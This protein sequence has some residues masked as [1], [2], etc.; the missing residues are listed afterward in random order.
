MSE[1]RR[2]VLAMLT[3]SLERDVLADALIALILRE[4]GRSHR[5]LTHVKSDVAP[6]QNGTSNSTHI[7]PDLDSGSFSLIPDSD[8]S[9]PL[10]SNGESDESG[11]FAVP[12]PGFL[13]FWGL[14]PK[15]VGKSDAL[16]AWRRHRPP[17]TKIRVT[18]AWQV[19]SLQW[20]Q[21]YVPN[22]STYINQGRWEDEPPEGPGNGGY[23]QKEIRGMTAGDMFVAAGRKP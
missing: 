4:A 11:S 17:I 21:G 5:R 7:S 18:L 19:K 12:P 10:I 9:K 14:Y 6:T 23:S 16:R 2:K 8:P 15:K 1:L 3:T 13:E 22:P 20:R